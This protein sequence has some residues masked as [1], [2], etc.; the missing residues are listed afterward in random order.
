MSTIV[1]VIHGLFYRL[2]LPIYYSADNGRTS[3][4]SGMVSTS[5]SMIFKA[6]NVHPPLSVIGTYLWIFKSLR[7][8]SDSRIPGD[9][10]VFELRLDGGEH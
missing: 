3:L 6:A 9:A 4:M 7:V 2:S 5:M 1:V 10:F 8:K